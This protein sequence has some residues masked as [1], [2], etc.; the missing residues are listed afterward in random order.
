MNGRKYHKFNYRKNRFRRD[1]SLKYEEGLTE[2]ELADLNNLY[3][4]YDA[5][6]TRWELW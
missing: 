1:A 4:V 5:G 6:K 3:R 2:R